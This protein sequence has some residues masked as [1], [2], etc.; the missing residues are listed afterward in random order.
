MKIKWTMTTLN[1]VD[2]ATRCYLYTCVCVCAN[3]SCYCCYVFHVIK[4][5]SVGWLAG[6][7]VTQSQS[8]GMKWNENGM[9]KDTHTHTHTRI[10]FSASLSSFSFAFRIVSNHLFYFQFTYRKQAIEM[11]L[12]WERKGREN[13]KMR[14]QIER[15]MAKGW[16]ELGGR[17]G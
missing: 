5:L 2:D 11:D 14:T 10:N 6:W 1:F 16:I 3:I 13:P 9:T 4:R 7:R 17:R 8:N 12:H 15:L